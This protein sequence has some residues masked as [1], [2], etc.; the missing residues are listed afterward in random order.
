MAWLVAALCLLTAFFGGGWPWA[1]IALP[2]LAVLVR[3]RPGAWITL[4][5]V[6][7]GLC[8]IALYQW[9]GDRRFFFPYAMQ[10]AAQMAALTEGSP[11]RRA[12]LGG[13]SVVLAF[14]AI[15]VMQAAS[16]PVL[17]VEIAVAGVVLAL[18]P[19]VYRRTLMA[20]TLGAVF[21]SLLAYAGLAF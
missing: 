10:Y 21:T 17:L 5:T 12:I 13:G 6:L 1:A 18:S 8:W 11:A 20:R 14:V 4:A 7:P 9:T 3:G 2:V 16:A 15:R 19:G